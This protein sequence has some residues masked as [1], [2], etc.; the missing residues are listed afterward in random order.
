MVEALVVALLV[1]LIIPVTKATNISPMA[2]TQQGVYI[3]R[4]ITIN[5]T[6]VNYWYGI[7][8]V[9]QPIDDLRW[10][11]PQALAVSNGTQDA[12]T[13]NTCPQQYSFGFLRTEA[14]LTLNVHAP[15]NANNLP[16]FVWIHGGGAT[17]GLGAQYNAIPFVSTSIINSIPIVIVTINYRLG[18]LGFL[19]DEALYDERT[20]INNRSTTGNY[21]ILD[22]IMA[23]D[24]IKKNIAGFGGNPEQITVGGES[25]GGISTTILLT[26]SLV[27]HGT[28]QRA[29]VG[30]GG[31]WPNYVKTLQKAIN[32]SGN[33]LRAITNCTTLQCLRNLAVDQIL[34]VQNI[35]ASKNV[36]EIP[37]A[38]VI[39]GYVL[40]DIME[41]YYAKGNFQ[42]VPILIGSTANETSSNVCPMFN[43]TAN[44]TQVQ[45][46][47]KVLYNTTIIDEIPTVYDPISAYKNPLM[48]LNIVFS[49]SWMHC[50]SRRIASKFSSYGLA[51]YLYTYNHLVPVAPSC[52][53]VA[54]GTEL[55][56]LFPSVLSYFFPNYNLST[57]EQQLSTNMMLYWANFIHKSNPN[58]HGNPANWDAYHTS[59]DNDF[60]LDINAQMR[61]YYYDATC[62]GLWD[63]YAVTNDTL[64]SSAMRSADKH[65]Y[66]A[67]FFILFASKFIFFLF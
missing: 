7:P 41:N 25:A 12:Y 26:S 36:W 57:S 32:D 46:F 58:Y 24:W 63:L 27:A 44:S 42:K 16:V 4:Q 23:L 31:M 8:Y 30:S 55:P 37:I 29:I 9:Q 39:D 18:L 3:G 2:P 49:D 6:N 1:S 64:T 20:G 34:V 14:C 51:S 43:G 50:G 54:H 45:T 11:P 61:S 13:P 10:M 33:V 15:E 17:A 59:T 48:Y 66:L 5:G 67:L 38:P 35:I 21:A 60:V 62:S 56:M 53:G 40:N 28:F 22:Q 19:A 47:F 65:R 52:F